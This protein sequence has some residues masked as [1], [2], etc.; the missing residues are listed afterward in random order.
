MGETPRVASVT[1]KDIAQD[2]GYWTRILRGAPDDFSVRSK[3]ITGLENLVE[4]LRGYNS[5]GFMIAPGTCV[6]TEN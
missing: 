4:V 3:A 5:A 2:V 1:L 6:E